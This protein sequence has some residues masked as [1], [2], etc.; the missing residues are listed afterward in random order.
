[1]G[2]IM[3]YVVSAMQKRRLRREAARKRKAQKEEARIEKDTARAVQV[4]EFNRQLYISC[5][6]IPL[7]DIRYVGDVQAVLTDA[8]KTRKEY[9]KIND[10][11]IIRT[12]DK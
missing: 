9:I 3:D 2:K 1:M 5:D 11:K 12:D 8:R 10:I 4:M 7:I 6:G